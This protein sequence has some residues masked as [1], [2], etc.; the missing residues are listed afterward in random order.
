MLWFSWKSCLVAHMAVHICA[1]KQCIIVLD[2][3]LFYCLD[4]KSTG[5]NEDQSPYKN[6]LVQITPETASTQNAFGLRKWEDWDR[7]DWEEYEK[8][9]GHSAVGMDSCM[10]NEMGPGGLHLFL[11]FVV[12]LWSLIWH[13]WRLCLFGF[14]S[15]PASDRYETKLAEKTSQTF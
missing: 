1:Y 9:M 5:T 7:E 15:F 10:R 8:A 3:F 4:S 14:E 2:S 11:F 12:W 13:Y 6:R